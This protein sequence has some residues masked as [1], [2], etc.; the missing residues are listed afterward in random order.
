MMKKCSFCNEE[1]I[2]GAVAP[3]AGKDIYFRP[4]SGETSVVGFFK[5]AMRDS[6]TVNA[7]MCPKCGKIELYAN[8]D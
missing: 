3:H 4:D 2:K 8:L 1:L 7:F 6:K 5:A